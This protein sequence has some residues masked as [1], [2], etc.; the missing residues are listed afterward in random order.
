VAV[1]ISI[2]VAVIGGQSL[3]A[4][5][6]GLTLANWVALAQLALALE[7]EAAALLRMLHPAFERILAALEKGHTPLQAAY[8]VHKWL[9]DNGEAAIRAQ[10]RMDPA[11]AE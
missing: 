2:L 7:P 1:L 3:G 10:E 9:A 6:A 11:G 5:L 8:G 4:I